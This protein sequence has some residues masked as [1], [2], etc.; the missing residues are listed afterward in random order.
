RYSASVSVTVGLA[1]LSAP[2]V[3][4]FID[5]DGGLNLTWTQIAG[6]AHYEV[7]RSETPGGPYT[8]IG[9][10][11]NGSYMGYLDVD[12]INGDNQYKSYYYVVTAV[13]GSATSVVSNE[14]ALIRPGAPTNVQVVAG[15]TT[16]TV[17]WNSVTHAT[18][19]GVYIATSVN[20]TYQFVGNTT[21]TTKTITELVNGTTYYVKVIAA[22]NDGSSSYSA[23][24]SVT[25]S[26]QIIISAP[27]NVQVVAG[28]T[29]A[30]VT[31]ASVTHATYYGVYIATSANGTYQFVGNTTSTTKTITELVN[32]TTYYVKVIASNENGSSS[33]SASVSVTVSG[34]IIISA[35]TNVQVV[36]GD[37]TAT[38]T[39]NSVTHA[40]Y[41]GVYIATS[42]NG[43][44]QF[45]GNTT[46][47]TK[48]ITELVNGTT[49]Y[50]KVIASNENGSSSYSA[51]VSVT[52]SGQIII[53]A[54][55]N[56]QVVA[57]D[58]TATVT[59]ASV[60]HATYYGVYIATSV[61]GTYQFVGNT[62]S[63]TK[64]IT[65]LVNGT[66]YYVKVIAS[67]ENGSSS[68]SASVSVTVSG[69]IIISA[70]TNVQVVA[71]DT[72]A[73]V[74]W[75][76]VTHATYYGVYIATS[77][78]GTY[79]F[80]GNTTS[81]TKT[82]TE[83]VN[84]TTYYIKVVA[85]NEEGSGSYSAS[86]SITVGGQIIISAPTNVQVVAG[87]TTATVTWNSVTH[88]TY[89]GVYIATSVNGTY[90]FVGSTTSTT[91][92]ITE[93][94]NG[95][96]YY[97]K[98]IAANNDGS[99]SY[100]ASVS[101][102]V[103]GQIIIS[104]PT[105]VQVVAGDTTATVTWA[106]VAHATYY[107]V[108][109]A[110]SVNGTY[111]FVGNTTSTTKTITELVNGTTYYV[112]V[113]AS[114]ENGSSSYSASVSVTISGQVALL[115]PHIA[116]MEDGGIYLSWDQVAG[117]TQYEVKRSETP[118]GPYTSIAIV[119]DE[120]W[121]GYLDAEATS[122]ANKYKSYYYVVIALNASGTVVISSNEIAL[123][124]PSTPTNV[125][126]VAGD[127]TATVTWNSVA[128]ATY[129]QIYIST[130]ENGTYKYVGF[131]TS[132]AKTITQLV[133]GTKY[134]IQ[135][136]AVN[137]NGYS[138][139]SSSVSV[140]ASSQ[141]TLSAPQIAKTVDGG[142]YLS[143]SQ[144]AGATQYEVKRSETPGGPYTSI[145]IVQD[146]AWPGYLDTEAASAENMYKSYYYVVTA[147]NGSATSV[148]SNEIAVVRPSAPANVQV[149]AGDKTAT[150]TWDSVANA[151]GY[152]IYISTSENGSYQY[153]GNTTGTT[154]TIT[155]LANGTTYYIQVV[156][157]NDDGS[158]RSSESVSVTL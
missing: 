137:D 16:A 41:Y 158:S 3:T 98:V 5:S 28:D 79:Q 95:T 136:V 155:Q 107:G 128:H 65:Q 120:P 133:N 91:K 64:T 157:G 36:A 87:D 59:W 145:A 118:G 30:T 74:T 81:T 121:P 53:S 51:S 39:W 43:T 104:A 63:T 44:Y 126:V 2:N 71:G 110:T 72:T 13:N 22:N 50:V 12:S 10:V 49:Y 86:V 150:V 129:Y 60:T 153:A 115:A 35:P 18:Y 124:R 119:Q 23:S 48:T 34:Q 122:G 125:Q 47:T 113:I 82:I 14:I 25:V 99:S 29:T 61:N 38:V 138:R 21:S 57:G 117:A 90:Q 24:V 31:W 105:N 26:G 152:A 27:T 70:P 147:L 45:V 88:A 100:S 85:S 144:V 54:P 143:W 37:T 146:G 108:Y 96:T 123:N 130:S 103:G 19:Y 101:I 62:T 32:G 139:S 42:V 134:Y 4:K 135:V 89:Y 56:V 77:V 109:I 75:A 156:A 80:V 112:K 151:N 78:N 148:S 92:T 11:Q 58:T 66:T 73:T 15:D 106:S 114:N 142:V 40:T 52:V 93:L 149:V 97:V 67:N 17:T 154:K 111:Q 1:T 84:G 46:S 33:Y 141:V 8:S 69:Q 7:K 132:T 55:T 76:S 127:K 94:V 116:K 68:Y 131:T 6:A 102:T 83:L 9:I 20:G 140:T